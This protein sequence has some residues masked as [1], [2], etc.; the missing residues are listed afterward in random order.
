MPVGLGA[1]QA[2]QRRL[3][4]DRLIVRRPGLERCCALLDPKAM[5]EFTLLDR[6]MRERAHAFGG[7]G[8]RFEIHMGGQVDAARRRQ[9]IGE[10]M[11][12]DRLQRVTD[13]AFDVAVI[14]DQRDA[15]RLD[16]RAGS[17]PSA[18]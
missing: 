8:K 12:A 13:R 16:D 3:N 14:N 2:H 5:Q 1:G 6:T 18:T 9:R 11:R 10:L 4:L 17:V 15:L 7:A